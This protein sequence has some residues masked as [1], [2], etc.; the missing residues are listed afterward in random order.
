[1][2]GAALA[3]TAG[4]ALL[5]A[6]RGVDPTAA[7]AAAGSPSSPCPA[8]MVL[9]PGG[10][11]E[12]GDAQ[13]KPDEQPV[14]RVEVASFCLDVDEVTVGAYA[15]CVERRGCSLPPSTVEHPDLTDADRAFESETCH[16]T[17][18][19]YLVHP[20]NCVDHAAATHYCA[21]LGQRLPTEEEWEYAARGGAEQRRYPWGDAD[22]DPTR[23]NAC[24]HACWEVHDRAGRPWGHMFPTDD[25]FPRTAPVGRFPAGNAR[26]G[27]HDLEGNVAEWTSSAPCP[28]P[29]T[30]CPSPYRIYRGGSWHAVL[31]TTVQPGRRWW[32]T[33]AVRQS[34]LGFRCA[35]SL[36][37]APPP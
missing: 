15:T 20:I 14:H 22:P 21:S 30:D 8:G 3:A 23:L 25:G 19:T 11:F 18:G 34:W 16:G 37:G 35:K 24:D 2:V 1:M 28:Y 26:W 32:A 5:R 29:R 13:G 4:G 10:A 9:L 6:R 31:K 7:V 27:V 12:M 17:T 33:P 36:A